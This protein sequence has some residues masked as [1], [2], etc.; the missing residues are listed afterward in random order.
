MSHILSLFM[1]Q[2]TRREL[3]TRMLEKITSA[4]D[5]RDE[6]QR[7]EQEEPG[8]EHKRIDN[9]LRATNAAEAEIRALEYWSDIRDVVQQGRTVTGVD[10]R[11]GWTPGWQGLDVSGASQA[12]APKTDEHGRITDQEARTAG[13]IT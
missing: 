9:L 3:L 6:H 1:F 13:S 12:E 10:E 4:S 11:S 8:E 5:H 2:Y 7:R